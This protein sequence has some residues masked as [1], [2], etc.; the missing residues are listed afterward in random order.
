MKQVKYL[1]KL[2]GQQ[3]E[4]PLGT[5]ALPQ[6]P[7]DKKTSASTVG[8]PLESIICLP[9]IFSIL[10]Y[11]EHVTLRMYIGFILIFAAIILSQKDE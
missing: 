11:H 8:C 10:I 2:C 5:E 6:L 3:F 9:I 1:C 4:A 7:S